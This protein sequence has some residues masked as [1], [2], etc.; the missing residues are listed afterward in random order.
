DAKINTANAEEIAFVL[1]DRAYLIYDV[2]K[3]RLTLTTTV[4]SARTY[5]PYADDEIT[6]K[7]V[8]D[9]GV[10]EVFANDGTGA[11]CLKNFS[12]KAERTYS[13]DVKG[14]VDIEYL[15][16]KKLNSYHRS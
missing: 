4:G 10:I 15:S 9:N 13:L 7:I 16:V 1:R 8:V 12:T 14:S 6:L 3:K 5:L 2:S 11:L